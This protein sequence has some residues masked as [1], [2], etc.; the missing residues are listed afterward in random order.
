MKIN[1]GDKLKLRDD[2]EVGVFYGDINFLKSMEKHQGIF[3]T[4]SSITI[5]HV[6]FEE[7]LYTFSREMIAPNKEFEVGDDVYHV[8]W[9]EVVNLRGYTKDPEPI[10]EDSFC[11]IHEVFKNDL[12]VIK[13]KDK[14]EKGDEFM[15]NYDIRHKVLCKAVDKRENRPEG[16]HIIYFCRVLSGKDKGATAGVFDRNVGKVIYE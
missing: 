11:D 15:D 14:L 12:R 1:I 13:E 16:G 7:S 2:L 4:V 6:H 10:V 9:G 3:L 8:G 5:D